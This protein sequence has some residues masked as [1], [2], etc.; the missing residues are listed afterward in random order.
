MFV[1]KYGLPASIYF[2]T[3]HLYEC[4]LRFKAVRN[5]TV[6]I[7]L[8]SLLYSTELPINRVFKNEFH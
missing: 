8:I 6:S 3:A 4:Y 5:I 7:L 2:S 1:S